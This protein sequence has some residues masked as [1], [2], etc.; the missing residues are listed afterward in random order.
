VIQDD[1]HVNIRIAV[2][3]APRIGA[4]EIYAM[5]TVVVNSL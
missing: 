1:E 2:R 5:Q 4:I 3:L